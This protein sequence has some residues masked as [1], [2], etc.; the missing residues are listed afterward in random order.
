MDF[1]GIDYPKYGMSLLK[2]F[3]FSINFI[4]IAILIKASMSFENYRPG[5]DISF[6]LFMENHPERGP[7][8]IGRDIHKYSNFVFIIFLV[9]FIFINLHCLLTG[10][11]D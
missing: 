10:K 6:P 3:Y 5:F 11:A 2:S 8:H 9:Q 1:S 7:Q 4:I